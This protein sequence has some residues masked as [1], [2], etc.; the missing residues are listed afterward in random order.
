MACHLRI[1]LGLD[2]EDVEIVL[3]ALEDIF[4]RVLPMSL[5]LHTVKLSNCFLRTIPD[6]FITLLHL[7][8]IYLDHNKI[9]V[10]PSNFHYLTKV[11]V[12][13][14]HYNRLSTAPL[15]M[16][17]LLEL[18]MFSNRLLSVPAIGLT[19]PLFDMAQNY[20]LYTV[21]DP[22]MSAKARALRDK[23]GY[24]DRNDGR[25]VKFM[26]QLFAFILYHTWLRSSLNDF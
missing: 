17:G 21:H 26:L 18:D 24:V 3:N 11:K 10:L 9:K 2:D 16:E 23:Y 4:P 19:T 8:Q 5:T 22:A 12:L 6:E 1:A 14:L 25:F 7:E 20:M 13:H 15:P